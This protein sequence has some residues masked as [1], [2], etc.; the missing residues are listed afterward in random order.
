MVVFHGTSPTGWIETN[1]CV[2]FAMEKENKLTSKRLF[3]DYQRL[4][5]ICL[6][7]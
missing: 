2:G 4:T 1:L 7:I 3:V 5:M 6:F